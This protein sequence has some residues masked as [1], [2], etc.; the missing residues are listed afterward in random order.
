VCLLW[1]AAASFLNA[2]LFLLPRNAVDVT[3]NP[4]QYCR[5]TNAEDPWISARDHPSDVVYGEN[6]HTAHT[7]ESNDD[8][9]TH[10]GS[11][12]W[13]NFPPEQ[14]VLKITYVPLEDTTGGTSG[15]MINQVGE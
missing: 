13:I 5:S 7:S 2:C 8:A 4:R 11:N 12:V 3:G 10:G 1:S 9:L 14:S 6:S 15:M